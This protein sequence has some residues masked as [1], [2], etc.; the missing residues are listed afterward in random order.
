MR[1]GLEGASWELSRYNTT[2]IARYVKYLNIVTDAQPD[3]GNGAF[4]AAEFAQAIRPFIFVIGISY[5][6][7]LY[8]AHIIVI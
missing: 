3:S 6:A 2:N 7:I 4:D 1:R 5:V 8:L